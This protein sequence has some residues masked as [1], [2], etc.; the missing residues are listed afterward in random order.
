MYRQ[1]I[2]LTKLRR[3][4][5]EAMKRLEC[6]IEEI[7]VWMTENYLCLND[8]KTEFLILGGKADL[9]K[10]NINHVTVGNSKIEANDTARNI[11]AHFDSTMDMKPHV[12]RV[13]RA[14]Y[15]QIRLIAKIRKYLSMDSASK[16][17]HAFVTSRL[18]NLNS[19]LVELPDYVLNKLQ[20]V[21][22]NAA[23][24]VAREKKSS[25]VTPLLKQLHWLPIEYR[26]K[27]KIVLIVY[28]CLHEMGPVYLTSLLTGYHPGTSMCLRSD[29]EELLDN[30]RTAKGYGDRAFAKSGPEL[31]NALPLNIRNSSS[32][33]AFKSSI[34][35]HYYKICY[36]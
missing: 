11:G 6:C 33:T 29:K 8:G 18:D 32:V 12:N 14:C 21:Q 22:N 25:H 1:V 24:L 35:T 7:R 23:R 26:I 27:Y 10:V 3:E 15:H 34:K 20:L 19:L 17:I 5:V 31:W 9:E 4:C 2:Y 30:K 28:K 36:V 13:I 16:L